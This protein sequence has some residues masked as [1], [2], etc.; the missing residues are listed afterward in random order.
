[1]RIRLLQRSSM[2]P[3]KRFRK[4][5][6]VCAFSVHR[7]R[8]RNCASGLWDRTHSRLAHTYGSRVRAHLR[9]RSCASV[10]ALL[11]FS[12][13]FASTFTKRKLWRATLAHRTLL[14][15][16][17]TQK[18][19]TA[20]NNLFTSSN[21]RERLRERRCAL[22]RVRSSSTAL[23][24]I[25]PSLADRNGGR[26]KCARLFFFGLASLTNKKKQLSK[27]AAKSP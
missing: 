14:S 1:M 22:G 7:L 23:R 6:H 21:S 16:L 20:Q 25:S 12:W 13:A 5:S 19:A 3:R 26:A 9:L 18:A 10:R 27:T 11:Y 8:M 2:R 15:H 17:Q 24:S 4:H